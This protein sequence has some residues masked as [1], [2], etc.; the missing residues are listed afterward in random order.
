MEY[1]EAQSFAG[2]DTK[3]PEWSLFK[4]RLYFFGAEHFKASVF[5]G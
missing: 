3:G 1:V 4:S 2:K 5:D